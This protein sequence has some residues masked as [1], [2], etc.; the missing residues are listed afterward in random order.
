MSAQTLNGH[1]PARHAQPASV[2]A[3]FV[4]FKRTLLALLASGIGI[5]PLKG[6][7]SDSG[8][9]LDAWLTMLIAIVPAALLRLRRPPGALDIWPGIILLIP[10]L[11]ARFV[12]HHAW[13]GFLPTSGTWH[14]ITRLMD[15]LHRTTR[16]EVAPIHSTVAVRLVVCALLGLL[17]AL[18]D[19]IA[20]VG[21]RGALAG[22]PLLVI[23][24]VSGAVPRDSVSWYWFVPAAIGF[25]ILL[26]LDAGD[27]L[28]SWG[29]HISPPPGVRNRPV[30]AVSAPRIALAALVAAV[31]LPVL[32]PAHPRNLIADAFHNGDHGGI[33]DGTTGISPYARLSGELR[34]PNP[35]NLFK[36]HMNQLAGKTQPFYLRYNVLE[37]YDSDGGWQVGDHGSQQSLNLTSFDTDPPTDTPANPAQFQIQMTIQ[38]MHDSVPPVFATPTS[39]TGADSNTTWSPQDAILLGGDVHEGQVIT[40][41][42]VQPVLTSSDLDAAPAAYPTALGRDLRLPDDVPDFVKNLV[43]RI[44]KGAQSTYAKARAISNY[45]ADPGNGFFYDVKTTSGDSGSALVDF[46]KNKR[47]FCQQY[48]GAMGVMLRLARIPT[49]V[50]LGYEHALPDT[51]GNFTVS[52]NDAHSWVEAYFAG[53]GWV[54][55]D[56]T[57]IEGLAGG[58]ANDLVYAPHSQYTDG[59]LDPS[60]GAPKGQNSLNPS[61]NGGKNVSA[62]A[63]GT[64]GSRDTGPVIPLTAVWVVLIALGGVSLLLVPAGLRFVRRRRRM[65][66]ARH[67]DA[68]ALWA[69]LSDTAVDLGYV[70][71]PARSPRQVATWLARDAPDAA[72]ALRE[73]ATAVEH[74]R[75]AAAPG[76]RAGTALA[77]DLR[78]VTGALRAQRSGSVRARATLWPASLGWGRLPGR[79]RRR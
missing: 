5:L 52:T 31:L 7:L 66:A 59:G 68:D 78:T 37:S 48:A 55:F 14:D 2:P 19:L 45:F 4:P 24:T 42:F 28:R 41:S 33:G 67:G 70:W 25:L 51:H 76:N 18:I 13:Y 73:L 58:P 56:P 72:P 46:L 9:L 22:V 74:S 26:A 77:G 6:L 61:K 34:Q 53:I 20:V 71:S 38:K 36:V 11:T 69:E 60:V 50:V 64:N 21:R 57:P 49:R 62:G 40:E 79:P 8:W 23:Y 35:V 15:A 16:E 1:P 32:V 44:T 63:G 3:D 75:Y 27:D 43:A 65:L 39:F 54:P 17:A 47:G 29:R 30:I 12:P 10:W